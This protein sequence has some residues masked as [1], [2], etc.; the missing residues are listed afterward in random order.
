MLTRFL[1]FL[2]FFNFLSSQSYSQ[3]YKKATKF[4]KEGNAL[5]S[6]GDFDSAIDLFL[7]S[8]KS[9]PNFCPAIYK[10]GLSYKKINMFS[11][12]YYFIKIYLIN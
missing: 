2:C 1:I 5:Y 8:L 12:L 6:I 11:D 7:K 4:Y 3:N 10:L 9:D